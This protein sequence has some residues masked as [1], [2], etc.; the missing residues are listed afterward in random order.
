VFLLGATVLVL[1][2]AMNWTSENVRVTDRNNEYFNSVN[3]AEAATEKVLVRM[4]RDY[5][6]WGDAQVAKNLNTYRSTLPT[7]ADNP[8]WANYE[9]SA[10]S[11]G[12]LNKIYVEQAKANDYVVL[13]GQYTGL[14]GYRTV[15]TVGASARNTTSR[16]GNIIATVR[17]D[18]GV[19][20]IP[21][22][23]F[24]IFYNIDLEINPSPKMSV[25]GR[26]HANADIFT[27][28]SKSLTFSDDVTASGKIYP[29]YKPGD[30]LGNRGVSN[31]TVVY[32]A[33]HDGGTSTLNLPIGTNNSPDNVFEVLKMPPFGELPDSAM[34]TN[35]YY[36]KADLVIIV[37]DNSVVAKSGLNVDGFL[38]PIPT[39]EWKIFMNTNVIF[40]DQ[41]ENITMQVVDFDVNK[42]RLWNGTNNTLRPKLNTLGRP[43]ANIVYIADNRSRQRIKVPAIPA[44]G[45]SPAVP[46]VMEPVEPGVRLFNGQQ[47]PPGGLTVA[48]PDPAYIR[49]DY[50]TTSDG[51]HFS[52]AGGNTTYTLPASVCA[53][54]ITILSTQWNDS[55]SALTNVT[56]RV[57][58]DTTVNAAFLSGI[59]PTST[60]AYS[61]GVE[62]FPRF[63][64]DW[65]GKTFTYN[66]SM[67][68][69]FNS[70][71]ATHV[72]PNTGKVYNPPTR[73]WYFDTNFYDKDKLPPGTPQIL[74]IERLAWAMTDRKL[75]HNN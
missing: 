68:V 53:D 9:F 29:T 5:V 27:L 30:P 25:S 45:N 64:E 13:S 16:H 34:G 19:E 51:T 31:P 62:N 46:A 70:R 52:K 66:G 8:Y 21:L 44:H 61:G 32:K 14:N 40:T 24:A 48:T 36:N 58:G 43:A 18:I 72:W 56:S 22:F 10:P 69:M 57:A 63:L 50:N 65:T 54:A 55:N 28:P 11:N 1:T 17:Q 33:E 38:T 42:F 39:N 23:Q 60:A 59:V 15:Y 75:N 3:A 47:L 74:F 12:G 41:R 7:A 6:R 67:V 49:G 20:A 37:S 2:G 35:R 71:I 26:V 73:D 4:S